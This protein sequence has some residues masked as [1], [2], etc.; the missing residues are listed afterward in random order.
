MPAQEERDLGEY[1][2]DEDPN[3]SGGEDLLGD[4]RSV[5]RDRDICF[6]LKSMVE[7]KK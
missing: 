6:D 2:A 5:V 3:L 7:N 1:S 4:L